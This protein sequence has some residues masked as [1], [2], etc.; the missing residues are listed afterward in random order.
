MG[1]RNRVKSPEINSRIWSVAG[2]QQTNTLLHS[3]TK[4]TKRQL[5]ERVK[6]FTNHI[7]NKGF[8]S[9]IYELIHSIA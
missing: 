3:K 4:A 6:I 2:P 1:Q 8:V 7:Y 5:T 9:R